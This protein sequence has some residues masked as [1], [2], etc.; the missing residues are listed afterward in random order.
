MSPPRPSPGPILLAMVLLWLVLVL[1]LW[2]VEHPLLVD[3]PNHV[4]R[5]QLAAILPDHPVLSTLYE[6]R[7][8]WIPNLAADLGVLPFQLLTD[9][10]TASRLVLSL[11]MLGWLAGPVALHRAFF[12]AWSAW[13][14]AS[15]LFVYNAML[16]WG[17]ENAYLAAP[18]AVLGLAVAVAT[19]AHPWR[20]PI[21]AAVGLVVFTGHMV[22]W[23]VFV[24][25]LGAWLLWGPAEGRLRS[26]GASAIALSPAL[27]VFLVGQ[28]MNPAT[29][30]RK[31]IWA[32]VPI[33]KIAVLVA[34]TLQNMPS[35]DLP[36]LLCVPL[37]LALARVLGTLEIH[38]RGAPVLGVLALISIAMPTSLLGIAFMDLRV[39]CVLAALIF[40]VTRVSLPRAPATAVATLVVGAIAVRVGTLLPVWRAHDAE[41]RELQEVAGPVLEPGMRVLPA[42]TTSYVRWH[43]PSTLVVE[44]AIFEPHLFTGAH[45]LHARPEL[46]AIDHP[47]T[48]VPSR[49]E[50]TDPEQRKPYLSTWWRDFDVLLWMEDGAPPMPERMT[51]L[52]RGSWFTLYR[53]D[54][55]AR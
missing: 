15:G 44:H 5:H 14:L 2:L 39:P 35:V 51:E 38:P 52:A 20:W 47:V 22:M 50:L 54:R 43:A 16:Y 23:G 28:L 3:W 6:V 27:V 25:C 37:L 40:G 9:P 34:P 8:R 17:F 33:Q 21:L 13:P 10:V 32:V 42:G 18:L 24:A 46:A 48:W 41:V 4:A 49:E 30:E 45:V 31:T 12:G 29:H 53:I 19:E 7:W 36:L 55:S 11:G 26:L 1:P